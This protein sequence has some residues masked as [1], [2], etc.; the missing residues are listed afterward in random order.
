MS[1]VIK[2]N[3]NDLKIIIKRVIKEQYEYNP[4]KLY[5]KSSIV[6]RLRQEPKYLHKYIK[7]LPNLSKEG[8]D[9]IFTKIPQVVWQVLFSRY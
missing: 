4:D 3:E 1:T 6:S 8:S 9:E 7:D 2:L 5:R